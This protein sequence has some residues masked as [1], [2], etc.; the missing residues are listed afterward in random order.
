MTFPGWEKY[1][2]AVHPWK[3]TID[4]YYGNSDWGNCTLGFNYFCQQS[5]DFK[6]KAEEAPLEDKWEISTAPTFS[7]RL[8]PQFSWS[9]VLPWMVF[10]WVCLRNEES[11]IKTK[12]L[13]LGKKNHKLT[14]NLAFI[15]CSLFKLQESFG[16]TSSSSFILQKRKMESKE[17]WW[18][19]QGHLSR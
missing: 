2:N 10:L 8:W 3:G 13:K 15:Y 5:D 14:V 12:D 18:P 6:D 11:I 4:F 1:I 9:Q 7:S 19:A 17:H 16:I